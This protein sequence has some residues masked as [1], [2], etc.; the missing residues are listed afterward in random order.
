ME[1][2]SWEDVAKAL[3]D[4]GEVSPTTDS[5]LATLLSNSGH[6]IAEVRQAAVEALGKASRRGENTT[7]E[8]LVALMHDSDSLVR[9]AAVSSLASCA[10]QGSCEGECALSRLVPALQSIEWDEVIRAASMLWM[11]PFSIESE[12]RRTRGLEPE[13]AS[14]RGNLCSLRHLAWA[15]FIL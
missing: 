2:S 12:I 6:E 4:L 14:G 5:Q 11:M 10:L 8:R 13:M 3:R 15:T 9:D 7:L 1:T